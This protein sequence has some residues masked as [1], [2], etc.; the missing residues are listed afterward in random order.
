MSNKR[1]IRCYCGRF[2]AASAHSSSGTLSPTFS[3]ERGGLLKSLL[4]CLILFDLSKIS[5]YLS[6][7]VLGFWGF[8]VLSQ[9]EFLSFVT[10]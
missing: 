3:T 8:G 6:L 7:G 9:F 5:R 2:S 10:I 1:A 4:I